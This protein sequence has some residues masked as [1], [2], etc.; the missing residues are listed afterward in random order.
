MTDREKKP[1]KHTRGWNNFPSERFK[2]WWEPVGQDSISGAHIGGH[3]SAYRC[4]SR[5]EPRGYTHRFYGIATVEAWNTA[6]YIEEFN[7]WIE[8]GS[9]GKEPF[10]S[11]AATPEKQREFFKQLKPIINRIGRAIPDATPAEVAFEASRL[12]AVPSEVEY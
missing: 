1:V 2:H 6:F 8:L 11:V 12:G 7:A 9:P 3:P 4:W 5:K 10:V